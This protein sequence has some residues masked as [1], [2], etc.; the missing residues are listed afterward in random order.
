MPALRALGRRFFVALRHGISTRP[1]LKST[2]AALLAPF[3]RID[4]RIRAVGVFSP[5]AAYSRSSDPLK[6][7]A[8]GVEGLSPRAERIHCELKAA[9]EQRRKETP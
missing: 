3:P 2:V 8:S 9:I 7:L 4:A 1:L 6:D 5:Q